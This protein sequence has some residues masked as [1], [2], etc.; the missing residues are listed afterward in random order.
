MEQLWTHPGFSLF[1]ST[2]Q[3]IFRYCHA[4]NIQ[5]VVYTL[6]PKMGIGVRKRPRGRISFSLMV[7]FLFLENSSSCNNQKD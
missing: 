5:E 7:F 1:I 2:I 4:K 3:N 6:S